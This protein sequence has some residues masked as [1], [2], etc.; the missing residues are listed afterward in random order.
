MSKKERTL[1]VDLGGTKI[2]FGLMLDDEI[3]AK[4]VIKVPKSCG[5]DGVIAEISTQ[6]QKIRQEHG[7]FK[8]IG[9]GAPGQVEKGT[10]KI[11]KAPN[12]EG[13]TD[14]PLAEKLKELVGVPVFVTNDV[15]A[16]TLAEWK[17]GAGKGADSLVNI[18]VGTGIGGGIVVA[19]QL[20]S[21]EDNLAGEIGHIKISQDPEGPI[22]GCGHRNCFEAYAG[23]RGLENRFF[24]LAREKEPGLNREDITGKKIAQL[25]E[26]GD[27]LA[28]KCLE[29][30]GVHLAI[31]ASSLINALNPGLLLIGG[32]AG[33]LYPFLEKSF[34]KALKD[35]TLPTHLKN[36]KVRQCNLGTRAGVIGACYLAR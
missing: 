28:L 15:R 8:A 33:N 7:A 9:I 12:L 10:G 25:A 31:G 18:Y 20:L 19:G 27:S 34:L 29:N 2:A 1:G 13:W 24:A 16:S 11:I 3:Q 35:H 17:L 22:C 26:N 32:G 21:G 23:G 14:V 4:A 5:P 30:T 6:C 36:L